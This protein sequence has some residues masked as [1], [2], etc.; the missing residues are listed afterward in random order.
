MSNKVKINKLGEYLLEV[1]PKGL[2]HGAYQCIE[3]IP[4]IQKTQDIT[5]AFIYAERLY[6][7]TKAKG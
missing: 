2:L 4:E 3:E 6:L 5:S 1:E 7:I